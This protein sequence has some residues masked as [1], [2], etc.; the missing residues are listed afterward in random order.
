MRSPEDDDWDE[1]METYTEPWWPGLVGIALVVAVVI[2]VF[3]CT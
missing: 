3:I 1:P 2:A